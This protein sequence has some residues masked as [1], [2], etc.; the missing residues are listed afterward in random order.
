MI[1]TYV[2]SK[3][4]ERDY[5]PDCGR[6]HVAD[7]DVVKMAKSIMFRNMVSTAKGITKKAVSLSCYFLIVAVVVSAIVGAGISIHD[8][9]EPDKY[10]PFD[11]QQEN[12]VIKMSVVVHDD[13]ILWPSSRKVAV[14]VWHEETWYKMS[15]RELQRV[16]MNRPRLDRAYKAYKLKEKLE[17]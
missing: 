12:G 8:L 5:C 7:V 16:H 4:M 9:A 2:R 15:D 1:P 6:P 13:N 17:K 11:V 3:T 14:F 10:I